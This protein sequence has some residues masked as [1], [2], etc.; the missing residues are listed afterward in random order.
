[1]TKLASLVYTRYK[2]GLAGKVQKTLPIALVS[3]DNFSRNGD[4]LRTQIMAVAQAWLDKGFVEQG[5]LDYLKDE[6]KVSFPLSMIDKITPNPAE[7]VRKALEE[8][9]FAELNIIVTA[10]HTTTAPLVNTEE[11]QYLVIEDKFPNGRPAGLNSPAA[12]K[13]GLYLADRDTVDK[14]DKMKV[15][16]CLN[17]LHTALAVFG[18]LLGFQSIADE[19]QDADLHKLVEGIGYNE[20]MPVVQNPG[21][22]QPGAFIKEVLEKRFPNPANP[23]TPQRIATD[24]SQKLAIRYGETIKAH[25]ARGDAETLR[26]IPLVIAAWCRYLEGENGMGTDDAGKPFKLSPDPLLAELQPLVSA[27]SLKPILSNA[28]IFAVDLYQAGLADKVESYFQEVNK[29]PGS[30]RAALHKYTT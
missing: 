16:A 25:I 27:G 7:R 23:D 13:S 9:G 19:M 14:C 3:T 30:V 29:G 12:A 26:L 6:S 4:K 21:I 15:C 5:Y 20:D 11:A 28:R 24:T 22:I 17:P 8:A 10:K 2:A 18:C 1:M